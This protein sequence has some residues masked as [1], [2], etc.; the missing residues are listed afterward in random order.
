MK[1]Y[2]LK[3]RKLEFI[4][5]VIRWENLP[6]VWKAKFE[7]GQDM[8]LWFNKIMKLEQFSDFVT[9]VEN[10]LKNYNVKILTDAEKE[11]EFM[12]A[13]KKYNRIPERGSLYFSDN[14]DMY[15][16]FMN[17]RNQNGEYERIVHKNIKE[18]EDFDLEPIWE[19]IKNE[20][21]IIIK[22]L[23]RVPEYGEA[24]FSNYNIDVRVV[25]EKLQTYDKPLYEKV[26]LHLETYRDKSLSMD[27]RI[28]ELKNKIEEL[29]YLPELQEARFSDGVDMFT[30]YTRYKNNI[31]LIK[32]H[33]EPII[34]NEK[35]NK[36]VNI[37]LIPS[38][39]N[40]TG[41][42]YSIYVNSGERLDLTDVISY[43]S[44]L[45]KDPEIDIR[46]EIFLKPN[47]EISFID[48]KKGISK[49]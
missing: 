48:I 12:R 39:K 31:S 35:T 20:F 9:E 8:R 5:T 43:E 37:Y 25:Y 7:D 34:K 3:K 4:K 33:I 45:K 17:Y 42:N 13:I 23:K 28:K 2:L 10:I 11:K 14:S 26:L 16:W 36:Q 32:E 29:G 24:F 21:I 19:D 18:Y 1:D 44:L 47:E 6:K 38:F 30:W 46:G 49:K 15:T 41:T 22:R 40:K 27:D